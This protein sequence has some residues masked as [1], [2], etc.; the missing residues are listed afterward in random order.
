M[1]ASESSKEKGA[2]DKNAVREDLGAVWGHWAG[3]EGP[4]TPVAMRSVPA[5]SAG[6]A[7]GSTLDGGEM[8]ELRLR[9][10]HGPSGLVGFNSETSLI[11]TVGVFL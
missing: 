6:R 11:S 2:M 1:E 3:R 5:F 7:C 9:S 10:R 4:Q 8:Q